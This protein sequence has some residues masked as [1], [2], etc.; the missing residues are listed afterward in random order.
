MAV[1]KI[2]GGIII[3]TAMFIFGYFAVSINENFNDFQELE[4]QQCHTI[5]I[6]D[7]FTSVSGGMMSVNT[8]YYITSNGVTYE[9][10]S[11]YYPKDIQKFRDINGSAEVKT[12]KEYAAFCDYKFLNVNENGGGI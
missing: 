6:S 12:Y 5:P 1:G 3:I 8:E 4:N 2:M 7:K 11:T 10:I 9:L